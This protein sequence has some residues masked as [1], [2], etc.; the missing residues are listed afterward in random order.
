MD[1]I[2]ERVDEVGLSAKHC[3]MMSW[4]Q[5]EKLRRILGFKF[6]PPPRSTPIAYASPRSWVGDWQ[7]GRATATPHTP[8]PSA[9]HFAS[10]RASSPCFAPPISP[11]PIPA[12]PAPRSPRFSRSRP[13]SKCAQKALRR[14]AQRLRGS[15]KNND[16][17]ASFKQQG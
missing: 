7:A 11:F 10:R 12:R 2:Q 6:F 9:V 17:S 8:P 14:L 5:W 3:L 13:E 16:F 1:K 15:W 4:G